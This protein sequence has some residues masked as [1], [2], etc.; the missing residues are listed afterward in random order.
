VVE[1]V[2]QQLEDSANP[3]VPPAVAQ[4]VSRT[5]LL[6]GSSRSTAEVREDRKDR[7]KSERDEPD[8]TEMNRICLILF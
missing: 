8:G 6:A 4:G 1:M 2:N 5:S 7:R 3:R